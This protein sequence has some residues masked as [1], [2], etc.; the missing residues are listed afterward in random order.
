MTGITAVV[1]AAGKGKRMHSRLAKVLHQVGGRPMLAHVIDAVRLAGVSR[2]VTVL[3]HGKEEVLDC[4][5]GLEYVVQAEQLGT[6]HAV[7]QARDAVGESPAVL[8][9][10]GDVPLLRPETIKNLLEYHVEANS[11]GTVLTADLSDPTGY[12][13][14]I[15][16]RRTGSIIKIVEEKDASIEEKRITEINSGTYVFSG[17][18]L[19]KALEGLRPENLQGEYYLTDVIKAFC[20]WSRE[21]AAF[22]KGGPEEII[23]INDR[24]Q[25]ADAEK[26]LRRRKN[27]ELMLAGVSIIDPDS[28]FIDRSVSIGADTVVYPFTIIKGSTHIGPGCELGPS[29]TIK[30]CRVDEGSIVQHSVLVDSVVGCRC[31][32]GPYA[33]LRPGT[34]LA[35]RVKV[36]DFVELKKAEIGEGS[37][38]PHLSYVG[39]AEVGNGVNIGAGTITCNYDGE[40]KW[41]TIIHDGAFIGSNSNLV[42]P[43]EIGKN[44]YVAAGST[45]TEDVAENA[46]GVGRG[47]QRNIEGWALRKRKR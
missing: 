23:G 45:I 42:A 39:D 7:A 10:C 13:R 41:K 36:G 2:T 22:K 14:I 16:N 47:R 30:D 20:D 27:T 8:V 6:G 29:V 25:L 18:L 34:V 3:G 38:I 9:L 26:V 21:V 12:G 35:D 19:F 11:A 37:K 33:Y 40:K 31:T 32:V 5:D 15:R 44:A 4:F 24:V 46:L 17:P 28:T 43:V 1:L